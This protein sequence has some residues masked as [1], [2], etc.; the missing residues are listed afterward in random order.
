MEEK[1]RVEGRHSLLL[2][3]VQFGSVREAHFSVSASSDRNQ[4]RP[5]LPV[6]PILLLGEDRTVLLTSARGKVL[7]PMVKRQGVASQPVLVDFDG[8]GTDDLLVVSNDAIWG[9]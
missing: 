4:H 1:G 9:Y 2:G 7:F 3:R 6:R 5:G 8:D